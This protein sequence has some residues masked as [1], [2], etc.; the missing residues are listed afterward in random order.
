MIST[1]HT[2]LVVPKRGEPRSLRLRLMYWYGALLAI[3]LGCFAALFLVLT[4]NAINQS[5]ENDVQAQARIASLAVYRKLTPNSPYWPDQLALPTIDTFRGPGVAVEIIDTQGK[6]RYLSA[7]EA[8]LDIPASAAIRRSVLASRSATWYVATVEGEHARVEAL[9]IGAPLVDTSGNPQNA[10]ANTDGTLTK[11]GHP[12]GILLVAESLDDVDATLFQLKALLLFSGLVTLAGTLVVSWILATRVLRP[13]S[14]IV[15]TARA[16]V[17]STASG[18][19]LGSLRQRIPRPRSHDEMAQVVDTLNEMLDS[20]ESATESQ[21]RFVADASHELRVP[22]TAIK[23]NLAFLQRRLNALPPEERLAMLDDAN[24]EAVR[25]TQLVDSLLLLARADAA[26]DATTSEGGRQVAGERT[27]LRQP[28]VELDH[29]LLQLVRQLRKRLV[30]EGSRVRLELGRIEPVRVT[31]EEER[32]RR[33]TLILLDNALK[34]TTGGGEDDVGQV[35]VSLERAEGHAVL[36]V[37]DTGA[38]IEAKDLPHIFERFYRADP[39]RSRQ[40][41]GLGLSIAQAEV[42]QLGGHITAESTPGKGSTF[43]VWLPLA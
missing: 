10:V 12:I 33:V 19:R 6:V 11:V 17:A 2:T 28:S 27:V 23:G 16:I 5:V 42:E 3:A 39:S 34:Y 9:P 14:G 1:A 43:S 13:L 41:T 40:G 24:G 29:A 37:R 15:A 36:R 30:V 35:T 31:G 38:G 8:T 7:N 20:L 32:V 4:T 25:L 18:T 22:L 21:R 26:A